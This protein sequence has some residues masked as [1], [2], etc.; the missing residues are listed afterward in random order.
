MKNE[1]TVR[2]IVLASI[3][4]AAVYTPIFYALLAFA[5]MISLF[6]LVSIYGAQDDTSGIRQDFLVILIVNMGVIVAA[7]HFMRSEMLVSLMVANFILIYSIHRDEGY[8]HQSLF[9]LPMVIALVGSSLSTLFYIWCF[10]PEKQPYI[11]ALIFAIGMQDFTGSQV[12]KRLKLGKF[13]TAVSPNKSVSGAVSG[14]IAGMIAFYLTLFFL[15]IEFSFF[16]CAFLLILGQFG[17]LFYS[18]IKRL[19]GIKDFGHFLGPKGGVVDRIDSII[20]PLIVISF[21]LST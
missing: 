16:M 7:S 18:N 9:V 19:R 14:F 5:Y 10:I 11:F 20:F 15:H 17:D 6:E 8:F 3:L 21:Q 4:C 13:A 1:S 2:I 12:G